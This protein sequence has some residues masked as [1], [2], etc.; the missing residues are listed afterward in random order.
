MQTQYLHQK[1]NLLEW[2]VLVM[3]KITSFNPNKTRA[4]TMLAQEPFRGRR[5]QES[6]WDNAIIL[7]V[8]DQWKPMIDT[9]HKNNKI[10]CDFKLYTLQDNPSS[11]LFPATRKI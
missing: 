6:Y 10:V 8:I 4:N 2:N 11:D 3:Q 1:V 7:S 9:L 5:Q